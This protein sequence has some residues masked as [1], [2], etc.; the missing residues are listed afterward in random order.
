[1]KKVSGADTGREKRKEEGQGKPV[2]T[3]AYTVTSVCH[4]VGN[5]LKHH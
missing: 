5:G 1:M 4:S 3:A 2:Y